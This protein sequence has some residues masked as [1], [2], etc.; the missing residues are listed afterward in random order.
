MKMHPAVFV[1]VLLLAA[2]AGFGGGMFVQHRLA[3]PAPTVP[4]ANPNPLAPDSHWEE[5]QAGKRKALLDYLDGKDFLDKDKKPVHD[6]T[7]KPLVFRKDAVEAVKFADAATSSGD[8]PWSTSV[9][10]VVSSAGKRYAVH[11]NL[12]YREVDPLYVI[13]SFT[14]TEVSPQ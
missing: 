3:P 6:A 12:E 7:G 13:V 5:K 8:R 11:A 2:A 10:V 9:T 14:P 4:D 1:A